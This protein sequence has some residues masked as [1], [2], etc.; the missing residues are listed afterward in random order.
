[1]DAGELLAVVLSLATL[2]G[3]VVVI[4]AGL[5]Y[6]TQIRELRHKER[7]AMIEQGMLPPPEFDPQIVFSRGLQQRSL[8]FGIIVVGLGFALMFLIGIAGGALDVRRRDR[9]GRRDRGYRLHRAQHLRR[10]AGAPLRDPAADLAT[11]AAERLPQTLSHGLA[12]APPSHARIA[13]M[14]PIPGVY[15]RRRFP[16]S[17]PADSPSRARRDR[18]RQSRGRAAHARRGAGGGR[19]GAACLGSGVAGRPARPADWPHRAAARG[20]GDVLQRGAR[21]L[22]GGGGRALSPRVV[23]PHAPRPGRGAATPRASSPRGLDR[24]VREHGI[25]TPGRRLSAA[26]TFACTRWRR[27][28]GASSTS[29]P[30]P[31]CSSPSGPHRCTK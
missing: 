31:G 29:R 4:L 23:L 11:G 28:R 27:S 5:R 8:S 1:M 22:R 7:L 18:R 6:R 20:A 2:L 26:V 16:S 24:R 9:R 17:R 30:W 25:A 21:P 15:V 14:A 3:G 13:G 19:R 12:C 10:A